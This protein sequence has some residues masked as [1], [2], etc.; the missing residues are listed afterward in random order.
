M[1]TP[2]I[3]SA[4]ANSVPTTLYAVFHVFRQ[5]ELLNRVRQSIAL[6]SGSG[7]GQVEGNKNVSEDPLLSSIYAE[8]LRL[9]ID[10]YAVVTSPHEDTRVGQWLLPKGTLAVLNTAIS[11]MD[12]SFW[13]TQHMR[14]PVD[15]FWAERFLVDPADPSSGPARMECRPPK[16][17]PPA[18]SDKPYFSVSGIEGSWFPFGG[19]LLYPALG[20]LC[21]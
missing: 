20:K 6:Y 3:I 1:L 11:H 18:G 7:P 21:F 8:T 10:A 19:K 9:Y 17:N 4:V 5:P 14:H 15:A 12:K 16:S 2:R 13:N